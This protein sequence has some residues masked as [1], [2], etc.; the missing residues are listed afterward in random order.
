VSIGW[1]VVAK[2]DRGSGFDFI[3]KKV[4]DEWVA[5]SLTIEGSGNTLMFRRFEVKAVTK[6]SDHRPYSPSVN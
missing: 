4:G 2:V 1:G 6:Y 5:S 3:R